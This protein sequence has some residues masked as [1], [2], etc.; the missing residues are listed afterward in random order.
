MDAASS[1]ERI[2]AF[3]PG[4]TDTIVAVATAPGRGALAV[5][6]LSGARAFRIARALVASWPASPRRATLSAI[7]DGHSGALLDRA[8]VIRYDQPHSYTG[9]DLVEITTHGGA[10]VPSTI[11]AALIDQGA[12]QAMPGEFTRR[13]V[14]NAKVDVTQAEAVAD[15]IDARSRRAQRVALAQ[16]DGGLSRRIAE[17]RAGLIEI[18]AL[19]AYDI[20]FPEE[21]D[22]PIAADRIPNATEA[23]LAGLRALSATASAGELVREGAVVVLAGAPNV[24]KSSL[25]NA[26]LGQSR[27]IVT[28]IPG[29]TRDALEAVIDAGTW[30]LRLVDTAGLRT[31]SDRVELMGIEMSERY[32][33]RAAVVLACGDSV[34]TMEAA[35]DLVRRRTESPIIVVR[36]KADLIQQTASPSGLVSERYQHEGSA[37]SL[38]AIAVSADTGVGLEALLALIVDVLSARHAELPLDAPVLT[39]ARHRQAVDEA[40][41]EVER[42]RVAWADDRLPAPVAATHLRNAVVALEELIGIIG[43]DDVLDRVFSAFCVGK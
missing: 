8:I 41:S 36:T 25:F 34:A 15:L 16:L 12:R 14:L 1:P 42:F 18:E 5:I 28:D 7:G 27:A 31:T 2:A 40:T 3:L 24:G 29:T 33:D 30:A 32:L 10:L 39:R 37:R 6:R 13:A 20:D 35:V 22:G 11:V 21:D 38:P 17:L 9:E 19:L 43:V 26:L 23:A 4:S